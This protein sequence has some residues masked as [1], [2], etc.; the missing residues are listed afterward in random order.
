MELVLA[1]CDWKGEVGEI[2]RVSSVNLKDVDPRC[3]HV[4]LRPPK[5][6]EQAASRGERDRHR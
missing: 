2:T 6:F 4:E 5:L 3:I 1:T